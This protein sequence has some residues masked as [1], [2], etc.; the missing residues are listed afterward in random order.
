[1][2]VLEGVDYKGEMRVEE[3]WRKVVMGRGWMTYV[4][5]KVEKKGMVERKGCGEDGR[6]VDVMLRE[7]GKGFMESFQTTN[8]SFKI[9][10]V[11][12]VKTKKNS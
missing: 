5:D 8:N 1:M 2:R 11:M 6:G 3:I 10:F 4:M 9:F 12:L 7:G